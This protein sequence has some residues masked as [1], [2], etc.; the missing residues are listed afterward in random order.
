MALIWAFSMMLPLPPGMTKPGSAGRV[1]GCGLGRRPP[2]AMAAKIG[3]HRGNPRSSPMTM[4]R[5]EVLPLVER[6]RRW[7][8]EEK[9]QIVAASFEP[10]ATASEVARRAGIHTSQ[11]FRWRKQLCERTDVAEQRLVPVAIAAPIVV[12]PA[13]VPEPRPSSRQRRTGGVIEIEL[14][15]GRR[16]RVDREV[17]AEALRRVLDVLE[18]R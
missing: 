17:D 9:E 5:A 10:G 18:R 12:E 14:G 16:L 2:C 15:G 13:T 4:P 11:L 7:S 3:G 8:R 1:M 6:R